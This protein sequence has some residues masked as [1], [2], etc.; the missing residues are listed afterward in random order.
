MNNN[1]AL[2]ALPMDDDIDKSTRK[3]SQ[4]WCYVDAELRNLRAY[5]RNNGANLPTEEALWRFFNVT[6]MDDIIKYRKASETEAE[7][8]NIDIQIPAGN[9]VEKPAW[10]DA[11]ENAAVW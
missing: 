5:V 3:A 8:E 6:F 9:M 11:I 2:P 4:F 7:A 1:G 10:Q